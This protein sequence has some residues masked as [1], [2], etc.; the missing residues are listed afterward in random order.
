MSSRPGSYETSACERHPRH[1]R[2]PQ[3]GRTPLA[4][5]EASGIASATLG[6]T[7]TCARAPQR[8]A[9][10]ETANIQDDPNGPTPP[11]HQHPSA[12]FERH[13]PAHNGSHGVAP[14]W[15]QQARTLVLL[16]RSV[17]TSSVR[18][19]AL[20]RSSVGRM[21]VGRCPGGFKG[22]KGPK[23]KGFRGFRIP[24]PGSRFPVPVQRIT[25]RALRI[26]SLLS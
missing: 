16:R 20:R 23:F 19:W 18:I 10:L 7:A 5:G 13:S 14:R 2:R 1:Q 3:P 22:F 9:T 24:V 25:H 15:S 8:G 6:R 17:R 12:K 11:I 4:R 21:G 26:A